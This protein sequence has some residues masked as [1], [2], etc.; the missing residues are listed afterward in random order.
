MRAVVQRVIEAGVSVDG[1]EVGRIGSGLLVYL[2]VSQ[3]D[4]DKDL[5][6]LVSKIS[7]LRIFRDE[8]GPMNR[9]VVD[10]GGSA[11]VV[12]QFTL[13]GDVRRGR[14][15]SFTDA[16]EPEKAERFY[17][18]FIAGLQERHVPCASGVFGAMMEIHSINDGPVTILL[19]STKLF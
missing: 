9:S 3:R 16:M 14:R 12:S 13:L 2:G 7:G 4:T 10:V 19:D 1:K 15:P 17:E 6:Y 8:K 5:E 11:L 18:R